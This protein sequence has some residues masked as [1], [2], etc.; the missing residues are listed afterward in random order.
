V[1]A[2]QSHVRCLA[3]TLSAPQNANQA[4]SIQYTK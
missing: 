3:M 2:L 4:T 1:I